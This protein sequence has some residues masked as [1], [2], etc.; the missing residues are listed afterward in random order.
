MTGDRSRPLS[1]PTFKLKT[2]DNVDCHTLADLLR[3]KYNDKIASFRIVDARYCYEFKGGHIRGAENFGA[4]DEEAFFNEFLPKNLGTIESPPGKEEKANIIIFHCEFS[5]A[6]GPTLMKLLRDRYIFR[7]YLCF[8]KTFKTFFSF[9]RDR[10]V[11]VLNYP[12]LHYPEIYLL[13]QGYK[14]FYKHYP[15]LCEPR[16]YVPMSDPAFAQEERKFHRKSKSWAAPGGT[17]SRTKS[18]SR[19]LKL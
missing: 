19:L 1:L 3:G 2:L 13:S 6:R 8:P 14:E 9:Y 17:I 5:S 12:A 16:N 10:S 15:E 4:W 18:T 7:S 11:N